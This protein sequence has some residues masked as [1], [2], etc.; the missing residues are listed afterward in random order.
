MGNQCS[1]CDFSQCCP[2]FYKKKTPNLPPK[3]EVV[4]RPKPEVPDVTENVDFLAVKNWNLEYDRNGEEH[5]TNNY[6]QLSDDN[7]E[8][9]S[10][11]VR[12]GQT[13]YITLELNVPYDPTK[14]NISLMFIVTGS[15]PNF[16]N[17]TLVGVK[18]GSE[19]DFKGWWAKIHSQ[20][21]SSIT[22]EVNSS[23]SSIVGKWK[24]EVDT[25]SE[26]N[27]RTF[28]CPTDIYLLFNAWCKDDVVFLGDEDERK[29]FILNETGLIWRGTHTRL[30]PCPWQFGQFEKNI[31]E[32]V[33][34]LLNEL[35][36]V[37]PAHRADPIV[38]VRAISAG[39]NSPNDQG[40]LVGN[41][42]GKYEGGRSPT[43]WRDSIAILQQFYDK[44]KSVKYGQCWVF[45]G[46]VTTACRTL[47]IPCR[48]VTNF[49]SAHDTHNSLSIDYFFG[50]EG[51]TIEELNADSIWN[52]HVWNEVW[53]ARPDLGDGYEGWQ[54]IDSTPQEESDGQYRCGPTSLAA[55]KRG[56]IHRPYDSPFVYAEVNADTLYWKYQGERQP[57]KLLGRK[58]GGIGLN[59]S[60]KAVGKM[61]RDDI[62]YLYKYREESEEERNIMTEA[63]RR[64]QNVFARYY[65]N[66]KFE[67]VEFKLHLRD[68]IV[69]GKPFKVN[70][71]MINKSE[72]E[73]NVSVLLR[74]DTM[75]Y[76]GAIKESVK[77][78]Q[79]NIILK[80]NT[81]ESVEMTVSFDEYYKKLVDQCAFNI[82]CLGKVKETNFEYF[83]QDDF[84]VRKPDIKIQCSSGSVMAGKS[85]KWTASFENPLPMKLSKGKFYI[86]PTKLDSQFI[87]LKSKVEENATASCE[88]EITPKKA[89]E[90]TISVMFSSKELEDVD[91]FITHAVE[92]LK[93]E[94]NEE[95]GEEERKATEKEREEDNKEDGKEKDTEKEEKAKAEEEP[96]S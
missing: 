42:S 91:G 77:S 65:L 37:S 86:T 29:E 96:Q 71:S 21:D 68:D 61:R 2:W 70:V 81:N 11:I 75:L 20:N 87:K 54:V 82:S 7:L 1:S 34:F 27:T 22:I 74:A 49:E 85:S 94:E 57:M 10:L 6:V 72:N 12:R 45:S 25:E 66:Q 60:T 35:C 51:E 16:G 28:I 36:K 46:V 76:T 83:A 53:M 69:I 64:C 80:P 92:E 58:T 55:I 44:K 63:L 52:F 89:G 26:G 79:F 95:R 39:V 17:G 78:H 19:E 32:C 73:H 90:I 59:I 15:N 38:V 48:P 88:F 62:T 5:R 24:L 13:F 31:L 47:G 9:R 84:R 43:D 33:L 56:E 67:D 30:R 40:I 3:T 14:H 23:A 4:D 50:D 41:W 8:D 18:V 93:E